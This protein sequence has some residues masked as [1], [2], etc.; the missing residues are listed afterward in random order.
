M[1]KF[2][3]WPKPPAPPPAP[4]PVA[5][6]QPV[7]VDLSAEYLAAEFAQP[8]EGFVPQPYADPA[9]VWTIGY[10]ST[11]DKDN[12]PVTRFT[13]AITHDEALQLMARDM[14]ACSKEIETSC[15]VALTMNQR[16]ALMDFIYNVGSG[17]FRSSTLLRHL[18]AGDYASAADEF[19][20]WNHAG[21]KVLAGLVKRREAE[22]LLF[23][24]A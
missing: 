5:P 2:W 3:W 15:K 13:P 7:P 8:F 14:L 20:K 9:G 24:T 4:K 12:E 21:G 16:V 17:N 6:P 22:T 18:N 11:R 23:E 10:G 1:A 19:I